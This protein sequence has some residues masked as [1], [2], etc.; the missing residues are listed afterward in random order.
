MPGMPVL[1]PDF[2]HSIPYCSSDLV[3]KCEC[4]TEAFFDFKQK[5]R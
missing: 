2:Q 5:M 1:E 3:E 4:N